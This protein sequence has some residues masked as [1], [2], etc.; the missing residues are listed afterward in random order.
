M[1]ELRQAALRLHA[2]TLQQQAA[3]AAQ[4]QEEE[5]ASG[6]HQQVLEQLAAASGKRK[7]GE[8]GADE[9]PAAKRARA[10]GV[11]A[12]GADDSAEATT[13]AAT[14]Q[15]PLALGMLC[16]LLPPDTLSQPQQQAAAGETDAQAARQQEI[17]ALLLQLAALVEQVVAAAPKQ[18]REKP[19]QHIPG[20]R[21][22][23]GPKP[24]S[25]Q[26]QQLLRPGGTQVAARPR[27][28]LKHWAAAL[29]AGGGM[30]TLL[31]GSPGGSGASRGAGAAME[32]PSPAV[33]AAMAMAES[34]LF[35]AET[36]ILGA[37]LPACVLPVVPMPGPLP[38]MSSLFCWQHLLPMPATALCCCCCCPAGTGSETA[39]T[40]RFTMCDIQRAFELLA[41]QGALLLG[42][43]RSRMPQL[44]ERWRA[45]LQVRGRLQRGSQGWRML[46]PDC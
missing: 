30:P 5:A 34:L 19:E 35:L 37:C 31:A 24:L 14:G 46:L 40:N 23:P 20:Q 7:T 2:L 43:S 32:Q 22:R 13:T 33:T 41:A 44:S 11:A 4:K 17:A 18:F 9:G 6:G 8:E 38:A 45:Q 3:A 29:Q 26:Q 36:R 10:A 16:A 21:R 28:L 1:E 15:E 42:T 12:P 39:L 27:S 25:L